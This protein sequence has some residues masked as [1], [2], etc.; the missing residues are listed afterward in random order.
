MQNQKEHISEIST[1]CPLYN[2]TEPGKPCKYGRASSGVCQHIEGLFYPEFCP[3]VALQLEDH[4]IM[5]AMV[6]RRLTRFRVKLD[7][8][9][10][11]IKTKSDFVITADMVRSIIPEPK[12]QHL[13]RRK[14]NPNVLE[15]A[16]RMYS[17][18]KKL[19]DLLAEKEEKEIALELTKAIKDYETWMSDQSGK[20]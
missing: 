19:V 6:K 4:G 14:D 3:I 5:P 16:S 10:M 17:E 8:N 7:P 15:I 2:N 11:P 9:A 12:S 1:L 20:K 18:A 13:S